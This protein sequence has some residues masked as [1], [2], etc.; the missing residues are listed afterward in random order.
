MPSFKYDNILLEVTDT[1]NYWRFWSNEV[2]T[3]TY[4]D[5]ADKYFAY[6]D[7]KHVF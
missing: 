6:N 3:R 7:V 2:L 1:G 4:Q 5:Q